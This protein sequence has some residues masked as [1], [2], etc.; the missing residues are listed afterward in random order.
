MKSYVAFA[1]VAA[2]LMA[3]SLMIHQN[4]GEEVEP[5]VAV[6]HVTDPEPEPVP[7][8]VEPLV[9]EPVVQE[10]PEI[11][12]TGDLEDGSLHIQTM[13]SHGLLPT[14]ATDE[15]Y[16]EIRLSG[17]EVRP[18]VRPPLNVALVIDTSGSMRG[19]AI[20]QARDA[21]RAFVSELDPTDR[22]SIVSFSSDSKVEVPSTYVDDAGRA[23][24][25]ASIDGLQAQ[26][27]TA[28][29][30]GLRDG[31]D[32]V[33][34]NRTDHTLDRVVLM[35]D[36]IP[37]VG[38]T[39]AQGLVDKTRRIRSEG[40]SMTALGFSTQ[41]DA[42]LMGAMAL[43]GSGNYRYIQTPSD[44][45]RAFATELEDLFSTTASQVALD[46]KVPTGVRIE[47]AMGYHLERNSTGARI[48]VGDIGADARRSVVLRLSVQDQERMKGGEV[49]T[50]EIN[51]LDR[52][53]NA[54]ASGTQGVEANRSANEAVV[55]ENIN[56]E[57]IA[58][59]YEVRTAV[60]LQ[61]AMTEYTNRGRAAGQARAKQ[62]EADLDRA[63]EVFG[64]DR[65]R[66]R[67]LRDEVGSTSAGM[68]APA[69][70]QEAQQQRFQRSEATI[71][72]MR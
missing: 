8:Q 54:M 35:T 68:R 72:L 2:L 28:L 67:A 12:E 6:T 33:L 43:A 56:Q 49:A 15:V 50:V 34:A 22:V 10:L 40:V 17:K 46:V 27:M 37:N 58:R 71:E 38:I 13:L 47:E 11:R 9:P 7:D 61:E 18:E 44:F 69:R 20:V 24:L 21:A 23:R 41:Y 55:R 5:P 52:V 25:M 19:D 62:V 60:A 51:Y 48:F 63:E 64:L 29:S 31:V 26:G 30:G 57:V 3:L 4:Q 14:A 53:R 1:S 39:T 16:L 65:S 59:V 45:A 42:D 36:G 32:Q 70:S 66:S